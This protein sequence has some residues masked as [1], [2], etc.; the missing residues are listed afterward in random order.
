VEEIEK[1]IASL[2]KEE[3]WKLTD[4]LVAIRDGA[5][6]RELEENRYSGGIE[7]L[8]REG[9][10]EIATGETHSLDQ[11]LRHKKLPL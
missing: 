10:K 5:W 3:F 8:W 9:E 11:I 4:K 6:I 2:P 7:A 1:A